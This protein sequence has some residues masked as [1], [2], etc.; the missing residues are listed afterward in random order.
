MIGFVTYKNNEDKWDKC[1][2]FIKDENGI[3]PTSSKE[4][5]ETELN[6]LIIDKLSKIMLDWYEDYTQKKEVN[7]ANTT[8]KTAINN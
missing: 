5:I 8:S 2:P 7:N 3:R 1:I 4:I 6:N